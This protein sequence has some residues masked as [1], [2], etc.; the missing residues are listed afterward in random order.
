MQWISGS[1]GKRGCTTT[2]VRMAKQ[3]ERKWANWQKSDLTRIKGWFSRLLLIP[4]YD[5]VITIK[6]SCSRQPTTTKKENTRFDRHEEKSVKKLMSSLSGR[7]K[8]NCGTLF[9]VSLSCK[10]VKTWHHNSSFFPSLPPPL[11]L[12]HLLPPSTLS[13]K[14]AGMHYPSSDQKVGGSLT[15]AAMAS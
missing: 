8:T 11:V 2:Y 4:V 12:L 5:R 13:A 15:D 10:D 14:G 1:R 6:C 3:L 7:K 9:V